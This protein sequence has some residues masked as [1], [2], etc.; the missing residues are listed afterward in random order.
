M[1]EGYTFQWLPN[2]A[3]TLTAPDGTIHVLRV[4]GDLPY[5][6]HDHRR[7][8]CPGSRVG[9]STHEDDT[10]RHDPVAL[11]WIRVHREPRKTLYTPGPAFMG[12]MAPDPRVLLGRRQTVIRRPGR[13]QGLV[14]TAVKP[15][16]G[17]MNG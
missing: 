2:C 11:Q 12:E 9:S 15:I 5:L 13:Q 4:E 8:A 16:C 6:A 1:K 3:P 10:W 17:M 14:P 7:A